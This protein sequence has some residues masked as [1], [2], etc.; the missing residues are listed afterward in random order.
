MIVRAPILADCIPAATPD[1]PP[2]ITS[3]SVTTVGIVV[4]PQKK[5]NNNSKNIHFRQAAIKIILFG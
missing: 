3:T 4:A 2:P 5:G 1:A